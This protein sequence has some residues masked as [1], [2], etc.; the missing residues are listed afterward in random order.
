MSFCGKLLFCAISYIREHS[1]CFRFGVS[2][3]ECILVI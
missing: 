2:G 3:S 1:A